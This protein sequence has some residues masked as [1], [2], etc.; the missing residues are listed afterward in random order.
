MSRII[1]ALQRAKPLLKSKTFWGIALMV[2]AYVLP[3]VAELTPDDMLY[4]VTQIT[5]AVGAVLAIVG[6]VMAKGPIT[7]VVSA[8]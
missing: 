3:S 8:K 1:D 2:A 4:A 7:G 5:E 6:R